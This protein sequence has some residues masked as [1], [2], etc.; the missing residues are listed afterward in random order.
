MVLGMATLDIDQLRTFL[1]VERTRNF[2]RAGD[3]V[4]KTQSAVSMQIR[5]LEEQLDRR[6]FER[7]RE[8]TLTPDGERLLRYARDIVDASNEALAAFDSE[9]LSGSVALGTADD[10]AERYLP[11]I[12]A[13]FSEAN[14]LV[15]VSVICEST[16]DLQ[17]RIAGGELD[18][19]IVTHNE[20]RRASELLRVEPLHWVTS[21]RHSVHR[22]DPLPLALGSPHCL[23][24]AQALRLLDAEH[25]A[26][27]LLYTSYSATVISSA[28]LSGLAVSVLP[29]SAVRPEMRVLGER[30]GFPTLDP[31]EIGIIHGAREDDPIVRALVEHIRHS[32]EVL[33]PRHMTQPPEDVPLAAMMEIAGRPRADLDRQQAGHIPARPAN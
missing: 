29:E 30:D 27:R 26:H 2:T 25:R 13:G 32:L 18:V 14:P 7:G 12:L 11:A 21:A 6:L 23:W 16:F 10:Y 5:R 20:V 3:I 31:C 8:V 9:A 4:A 19:A 24:R 28:V 15:E 17:H 22:A 33:A 1:A